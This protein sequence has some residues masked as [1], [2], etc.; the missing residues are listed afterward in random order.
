MENL[1]PAIMSDG[2]RSTISIT[3]GGWA[4]ARCRVK[5]GV[6]A[7]VRDLADIRR[8]SIFREALWRCVY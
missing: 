2:L 7:A 8:L 5:Q 6:R 3:A 1:R 4:G